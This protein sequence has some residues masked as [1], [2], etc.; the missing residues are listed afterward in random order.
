MAIDFGR[1]ARGIATGYLSA[2]VAD[3]AA[4]DEL[5]RDF[6]L[7]A[8]NQ[9]FNVDK[10]NFIAE[11]KKR[12]ANIDFIS[13]KLSPVYANYADAANYTLS[14]S[15]TKDFIDSVNNLGNEDKF[16]LE[17]TITQRKRERTKTFDENNAFITD[18]FKNLK[19]GF[20]SINMTKMFF[21]NEG[22][23]I[24]EV[25][26]NQMTKA[27][28]PSLREIQG[29]GTIY[30]F[31]EHR[32]PRNN[33]SNF[34]T[35]FFV[36]DLRQPTTSFSKET[37]QFV[38]MNELLKGYEE[39][40]AAGFNKGKY[41]YARLK[42]ID[43]ELQREGITGFPT[44]FDTIQ[45]GVVTQDTKAV[46]EDTKAVPQDGKKFDKPDTSE[47]GVKEDAKINIKSQRPIEGEKAV[48][49]STVLNE[50]REII[51]RISDSPSLSDDEKEKRIDTAK[52]RTRDRL[53]SMGL[54]LDKFNI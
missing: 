17:S 6:I 4:Q 9:Y 37:P 40:E 53:Q 10:P 29:G 51:A 30:N 5:N 44:G 47:I 15:R 27:S 36:N 23:D 26:V 1:A 7:Q 24:A 19:G 16:K 2:K 12:S 54:D 20:G 33:A 46:P 49:V 13:T 43:Q 45:T 50:L 41:E 32:V 35:G 38:L 52:Q 25:G 39:A 14:D 34:F 8:R 21:P 48:S 18:Q 11:E 3:T 22:E 42:Y 31:D 28:I